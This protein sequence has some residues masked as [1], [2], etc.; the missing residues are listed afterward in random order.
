VGNNIYLSTLFLSMQNHLLMM[1]T[2]T[3]G[4]SE[5]GVKG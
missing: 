3:A 5:R 1:L 4:G 2:S